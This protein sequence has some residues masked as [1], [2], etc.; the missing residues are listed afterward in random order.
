MKKAIALVCSTLFFYV[1]LPAQTIA[2]T[3]KFSATALKEDLAFIK[4]Q[5]FDAHANPFTELTEKQYNKVFDGIDAKLK[6]SLTIVDFYKLVKPVFSWL[7]DEHADIALPKTITA[8]ND[9][10]LLLPISLK[11]QGNTYTID[12]ILTSAGGLA[13]GAIIQKVNNVSVDK[14]VQQ[15]AEYN[16]GFPAGRKE[17]ALQRF[18]Y[19]YAMAATPSATYTITLKGGK[20]VTLQGTPKAAWVNFINNGHTWANCSDMIT[21]TKYGNT[22]YINAWSFSTH[23]DSEFNAVKHT[24]D[25]IFI[26]MQQDNIQT[27]VIDVSKNGGGNSAVGDV[28]INNF[29]DKPYRTY[30]C[31]WRRSDEYLQALKKWGFNDEHYAAMKPGEILH[32]DADSVYSGDN[33]HRFKGKVYVLVGN[34]TFS[35]A[36]MFATI[37]KDN[38]IATLAG[39]MPKD[40]HPTHF[41]ELYATQTQNTHLAFRFGVKEWIRPAGKTGDNVLMPDVLVKLDYPVNVEVLMKALAR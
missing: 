20:E 29:Y 19:L 38:K 24:I 35:S 16:T 8:I 30:Q 9:N 11:Q 27:V 36:M 10:S 25:S 12:T 18:G 17:E 21:Y 40:G 26:I 5:L 6:D 1:I 2:A 4:K 3:S 34:G 28:I 37:I 22:G 13:A 33:D 7:S 39:Q 32:F 23:S 41:G 15:C 31:N 14:L